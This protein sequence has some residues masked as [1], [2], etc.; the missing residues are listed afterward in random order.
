METEPP[1]LV[2]RWAARDLFRGADDNRVIRKQKVIPEAR[3]HCRGMSCCDARQEG[4]HLG[5]RQ[6]CPYSPLV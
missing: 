2:F 3:G 1:C 5:P 6:D 4:P